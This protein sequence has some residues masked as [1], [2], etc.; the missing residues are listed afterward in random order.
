MM[1]GESIRIDLNQGVDTVQWMSNDLRDSWSN[2]HSYEHEKFVILTFEEIVHEL[3]HLPGIDL[4]GN[5]T[6]SMRALDATSS[7][8]LI[9]F[10]VSI[11]TGSVVKDST[12]SSVEYIL[13]GSIIGG[14]LLAIILFVIIFQNEKDDQT[15]TVDSDIDEIVSAEI[16]E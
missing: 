3:E 11:Q 2:I 12:E 14:L 8:P 7:S 9:T 15:L 6:I 1:K 4:Y 16:V 5:H 13:Y 10:D